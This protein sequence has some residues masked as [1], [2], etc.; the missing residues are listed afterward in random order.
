[1]TPFDLNP[2]NSTRMDSADAR[3]EQCPGKRTLLSPQVSCTARTPRDH[4]DGR[5]DRFQS[6]VLGCTVPKRFPAAVLLLEITPEKRP[7]RHLIS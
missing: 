2:D 7:S 3:E 6:K 1:M 4:C 5:Q